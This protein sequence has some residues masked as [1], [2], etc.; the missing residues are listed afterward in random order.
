MPVLA[1]IKPL[2]WE[3]DFFSLSTGL[4]DFSTPT[5][6]DASASSPFS[7]LQA[8]VSAEDIDR[9]DALQLAGFH[10]VEGE[11]DFVLSV[12][13]TT[14]QPGMRI[15]RESQ[16]PLLRDAAAAAFTFSR[17][18]E[19]WFPADASARFYA[20][21]LENAVRGTFDHQCLLA[22]DE[23]GELQ[24]F[25]TLRELSDDARVGLL[26]VLPTAQRSGVGRRLMA[27]AADWTRV[28]GLKRLR[29][30]TQLSN[31]AAMRLYFRSGAQLESTAYW[32]YR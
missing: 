30:A 4:L 28:R 18:R 32:L 23:Q 22:V 7:L 8:K 11:A 9:L 17:F 21:W 1:S 15:A 3:S 25:V 13:R 2:Q 10:V 14:R 26:A 27:A 6:L 29:V 19:P 16:I 20:R 24:G 31:L 12:E 5:P